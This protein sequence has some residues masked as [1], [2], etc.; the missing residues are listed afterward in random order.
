MLMQTPPPS[1][2][3]NDCSGLV[4]RRLLDFI[5]FRADCSLNS[6]GKVWPPTPARGC[7]GG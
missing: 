3:A 2:V 1:T 5:F 7:L 4:F 6:L